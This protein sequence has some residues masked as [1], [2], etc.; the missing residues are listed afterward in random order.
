MLWENQN[1]IKDKFNSWNVVKKRDKVQKLDNLI[2]KAIENNDNRK[3]VKIMLMMLILLKM[4]K[5]SD[6]ELED[7]DVKEV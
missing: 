1:T 5:N 6:I 4:I 2:I 3:Y 7:F